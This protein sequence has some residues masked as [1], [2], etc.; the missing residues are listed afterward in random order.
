MTDVKLFVLPGSVELDESTPEDQRR[1]LEERER[2]LREKVS[3]PGALGP[4]P[5]LL[6]ARRLEFGITDWAFAAQPAYDR[7]YVHQIDKREETFSGTSIIM[8][9]R[10]KEK[11]LKSCPMGIIVGA[12]A[13][14]L[15]TLRA[16]GMDLGHQVMFLRLVPYRIETDYA[17]RQHSIMV[18]RAGDII[19]SL[20]LGDAIRLGQVEVGGDPEGGHLYVN[21]ETG[22]QWRPELPY[23]EGDQ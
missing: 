13:L 8:T 6:E 5:P 22:E 2:K 15:D 21:R 7:V 10:T 1:K 16:N 17:D 9:D 12:G 18:L 4:L 3:P 14:A 23:M 20:D 19:G 11:N